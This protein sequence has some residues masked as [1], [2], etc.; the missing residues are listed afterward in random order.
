MDIQ[1]I[2]HR[3]CTVCN[4][5]YQFEKNLQFLISNCDCIEENYTLKNDLKTTLKGKKTSKV[6]YDG[7]QIEVTCTDKSVTKFYYPA[8]SGYEQ[9]IRN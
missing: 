1:I 2:K 5:H 8:N 9:T 7:D 4:A 6:Q 3:H